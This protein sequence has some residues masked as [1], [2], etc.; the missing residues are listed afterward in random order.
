M[1]YPCSENKGADQLRSH[2]AADLRLCF[3]I[4]KKPVFSQRG[5]FLCVPRFGY[6]VFDSIETMEEQ[7]KEKQGGELEGMQLILDYK[8]DKSSRVKMAKKGLRGL[9]KCS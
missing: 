1:C 3:R 4:C 2:C 6:V 7:L 8:N 5:S 9:G